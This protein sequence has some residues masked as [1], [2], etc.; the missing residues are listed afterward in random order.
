KLKTWFHNHTRGLTS[1]LRTWAV[2]KIMQLRDRQEWQVY[3]TMTYESKLKTIINS[4][5]EA[6]KKKWSEGNPGI[7]VPQGHFAS[8][9]SFLKSKYME[10]MGEVKVDVRKCWA[11]M[12]A[13]LDAETD[14]QNYAYQT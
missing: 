6:Y 2:L 4:E 3:Q 8:V 14:K 11:V 7:K 1:G 9:N 5:W 13:K 12:K 10:K